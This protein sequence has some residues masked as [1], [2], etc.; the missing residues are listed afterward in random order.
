MDFR[1]DYKEKI[2]IKEDELKFNDKGLL[3]A[4]LQ[5]YKCGKVLML[6]YMNKEAYRKSIE[7]GKATF[8]SRSRQKLWV[9]GETS[10][11]YQY[12]KDI[13]IDCDKDT[14]LLLVDPEGPACHTG[15]ESCFYRK[16]EEEFSESK[17]SKIEENKSFYNKLYEIIVDRKENPQEDSYTSSLLKKGIDR[18]AKKIGE[19]ASEVIIAG[20]N[21]DED[22]IIYETA[23]LIYHLFILLVLYDISISD[24]ENE[25]EKRHN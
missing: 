5:D 2:K 4:V 12:I 20:K 17:E 11:N 25:L 7:T 3:P 21:E 16:I 18:I 9:K 1:N 24:I 13:K 19:E 22:E 23:D 15:N 6:A 10:G 8:W 14:L